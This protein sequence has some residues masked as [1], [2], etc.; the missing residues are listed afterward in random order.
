[1]KRIFL[2]VDVE[3]HDISRINSYLVGAIGNKRYGIE[4]ILEV[5]SKCNIPIN[6]FVDV[7]EAFRYGDQIIER[8]IN[9]IQSQ[10]HKAYFHLHPNFISGDDSRT[11]FW[12]YTLAEQG[13]IFKIAY[14]KY[15]KLSK[16]SACTA[17]RMGRYGVNEHFY[18]ILANYGL[19]CIDLSYTYGKN[20]MCK[21]TYDNIGTINNPCIYKNQY[22][23]PNTAYIGLE[24][25]GKKYPLGLDVA[26]TCYGEFCDIL[27]HLDNKN[28]VITMHCW[29]FI[30]RYFFLAN[31]ITIN[32]RNINKL[33]KMI[34]YAQ[35]KG[36]V[37]SDLQDFHYQDSDNDVIYNPFQ[38]GLN[39][40]VKYIIYNFIRFM[41]IAR[42]SKKYFVIY[43]MFFVAF[44]WVV[45]LIGKL[46]INSASL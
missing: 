16:Y 22:I 38:Y 4:K 44:G 14:E 43:L 1:M 34:S 45:A 29:D 23:L 18:T 37:F 30:K 10:G 46:F 2:T 39:K 41:N 21:L 13:E 15:L 42:L 24:L 7:G 3:C 28:I 25:G 6:F 17:F 8:I 36:F 26:E 27:D 32:Y 31:Y 12:Q 9:K 40:K 20:K 5:A 19:K 11:F 35:R 33:E